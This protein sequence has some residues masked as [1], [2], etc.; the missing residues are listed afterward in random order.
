MT[1]KNTDIPGPQS[2]EDYDNS[3]S[4]E[5]IR[6]NK[7]DTKSKEARLDQLY[8]DFRARIDTM[9]PLDKPSLDNAIDQLLCDA[10]QI[11]PDYPNTTT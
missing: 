9:K 6:G 11:Y 10:R 2:M 7:E 8:Q 3:H 5:L 4:F 1:V